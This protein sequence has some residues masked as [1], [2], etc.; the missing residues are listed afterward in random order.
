MKSVST[1]YPESANFLTVDVVNEFA[2]HIR[3]EK[4]ALKNEF[5]VLESMLEPKNMT[6]IFELFAEVIPLCTAFPQTT[7]TIEGALAVPLSQ[8]TCERSFSKNEQHQEL[9]S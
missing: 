8:V 9:S 3:A 5:R 1:V 2:D 6:T 4:I 7:K